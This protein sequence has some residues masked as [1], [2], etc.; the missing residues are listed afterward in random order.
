MKKL[1]H[2]QRGAVTLPITLVVVFVI[3]IGAMFL[4]RSILFDLASS[5][6]RYRAA[7]AFETADAGLAWGL[8]QLN[9]DSPVD[10]SCQASE[11]GKPLR[12][13]ITPSLLAVCRRSE[14]G[15]ACQCGDGKP[16]EGTGF[17]VRFDKDASS[18]LIRLTSSGC[19]A[20]STNCTTAELNSSPPAQVLIGRIPALDGLP[21]AALT[22]RG[23]A[24]FATAGFELIHE[25]PAT[26]GIT[27]HAGGSADTAHL[28]LTSTPGTPAEMS[29]STNDT[30]VQQLSAEGMFASSFRMSKKAWREQP[31]VIELDCASDCDSAL[32]EVTSRARGK[33][34][35]WLRGGLRL[36]TSAT[37]GSHQRPLVLV[38]DGPVQ[39]NAAAVIHGVVYA[40]QADWSDTAG[41]TIHGAVIAEGNLEADGASHIH[42][43]PVVLDT[44]NKQAG[45]HAQVLGSWRDF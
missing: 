17:A 25:S 27:L 11:D 22:V 1:N 23:S 13:L 14:D 33:Q 35:V 12:D 9:N 24:S 7:Q 19:G 15:W 20:L 34:M 6:N 16:L 32:A 41:A 3:F 45:S 42:H 29:I 37:F 31:T 10:K 21:A 38:A 40:I 4:H 44:L 26:G 2:R 43:D 28:K 30:S 18:N 39:L 36:G 5:T 8:A